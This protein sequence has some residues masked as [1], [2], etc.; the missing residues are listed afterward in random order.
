MIPTNAPVGSGLSP[1]DDANLRD[2]LHQLDTPVLRSLV[3]GATSDQVRQVL[4]VLGGKKT[5]RT[6]KQLAHE[7]ASSFGVQLLADKSR[8][9][10]LLDRCIKM[11][12]K[13]KR[14][15]RYGS[16]VQ[17]AGR[18]RSRLQRHAEFQNS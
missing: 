18:I 15:L 2:W 14:R 5:R 3:D 10:L 13:S 12:R 17:A 6:R 16:L 9:Q 8:R 11:K 7:I 4:T 1:G